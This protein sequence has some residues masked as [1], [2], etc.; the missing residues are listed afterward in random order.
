MTNIEILLS[1]LLFINVITFLLWGHQNYDLIDIKYHLKESSFYVLFFRVLI[2]PALLAYLLHLLLLSK[3][4]KR[5][6]K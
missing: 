1:V 3:P 5:D 2:I 4:L 6:K